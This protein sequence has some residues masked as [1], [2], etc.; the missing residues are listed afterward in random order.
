MTPVNKPRSADAGHRIES[1][2]NNFE[3]GAGA[4][5]N[6]RH[7]NR[8]LLMAALVS[9]FTAL[10]QDMAPPP[11]PP[12]DAPEA[13]EQGRVRWGVD[14]QIGVLLPQTTVT[15]GAEGRVGYQINRTFG[16][17]VNG[18]ATFGFGVGGSLNPNGAVSTSLSIAG[19]WKLGVLGEMTLFDR[20]SIAAGPAIANGG[21]A[22]VLA[23]ANSTNSS[24]STTG[25]VAGGFMP[26]LDLKVGLN[27]GHRN[28][29]TGRRS[30]FNIGL[31]VL[32][33]FAP[34]AAYTKVTADSMGGSVTANTT[35]LAVG[36][37]PALTLGYDAR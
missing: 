16:A 15:F 36:V 32:F 25:V 26:A 7:M 35:G 28:E 31:D 33:L 1:A 4:C 18:G 37:M 10:A 24:S 30:G 2:G 22:G 21:W 27:L 34:N 6:P 23:T 9:S 20:L 14:G 13:E 3:S 17:F 5:V 19:W 12:P 11:P 8:T 29:R